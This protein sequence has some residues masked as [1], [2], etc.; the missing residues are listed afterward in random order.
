LSIF[1]SRV[2]LLLAMPR[3]SPVLPSCG[4]LEQTQ[5]AAQSPLQGFSRKELGSSLS[6]PPTLLGF[7][8]FCLITH[9]RAP[10]DS[11]VAS[12]GARGMS[13]PP[14]GPSTNLF[15]ALPEPHVTQLSASPPQR[16]VYDRLLTGIRDPLLQPMAFR[17]C[18]LQ[19]RLPAV[20]SPD[21]SGFRDEASFRLLVQIPKDL[22]RFQ[23][24][25]GRSL[26]LSE[27]L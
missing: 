8:A 16:P 19:Q 17:H 4:F 21:K 18:L 6:R 7:V 12:S 2:F 10:P 11:G 5:A 24:A 3:F 23:I 9:V 13:P 25:P 1:P 14:A 20:L 26:S 15:A 27:A 22:T